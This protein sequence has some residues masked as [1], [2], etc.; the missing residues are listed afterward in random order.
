MPHSRTVSCPS[1]TRKPSRGRV[2]RAPRRFRGPTPSGWRALPRCRA[3]PPAAPAAPVDH[4][5]RRA[6]RGTGEA[7]KNIPSSQWGSAARTP[8]MATSSTWLKERSMASASAAETSSPRE[9]ARESHPH[10]LARRD[11]ARPPQDGSPDPT[12]RL[13]QPE[14]AQGGVLHQLH[15]RSLLLFPSRKQFFGPIVS[16]LMFGGSCA[17]LQ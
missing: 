14:R 16:V 15:K 13:L 4:V 12:P 3:A 6:S 5:G 8:L 17:P 9:G 7:T 11:P 2:A 1:G 10:R